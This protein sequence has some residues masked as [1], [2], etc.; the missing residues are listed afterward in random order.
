MSISW[1]RVMK[2]Y[3]FWQVISGEPNKIKK[4]LFSMIL[5]Q[6]WIHF[7]KLP[8]WIQFQRPLK[9]RL[10]MQ[11]KREL[12]KHK[13]EGLDFNSSE[14]PQAPFSLK[15]QSE[16]GAKYTN[17]YIIIQAMWYTI[18]KQ[19]GSFLQFL[20]ELSKWWSTS[21][22]SLKFLLEQLFW[23]SYFEKILNEF[24]VI[25]CQTQKVFYLCYHSGSESV[26]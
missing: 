22:H 23:S 16:F 12:N 3:L 25:T 15:N 8:L 20:V 1:F 9:L 2:Q 21:R 4:S 10:E 14:W 11:M 5:E 26:S 18:D 7:A 19:C 24:L 6:V 13:R 17:T